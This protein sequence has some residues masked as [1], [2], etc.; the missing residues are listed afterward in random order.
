MEVEGKTMLKL[1]TGMPKLM[2]TPLYRS[3]LREYYTRHST[4]KG[5]CLKRNKGLQHRQKCGINLTNE[6]SKQNG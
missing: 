5:I 1:L 3:Q 4:K 6:N 2:V